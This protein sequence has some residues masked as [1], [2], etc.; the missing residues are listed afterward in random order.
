M[1]VKQLLITLFLLCFLAI[2]VGIGILIFQFRPIDSASTVTAQFVVTKGDTVS[3]VA[4]KLQSQQFIRSTLLFKVMTKIVAQDVVVQPGTYSLSKSMNPAQ[5]LA[6]LQTQTQ[7]VWVTLIEGWRNEEMAQELASK[8][9]STF[10]QQEFITLAKQKEGMLFP[11][12]YHIAK[13]AT[14]ENII[15]MLSATFT[16]RYA[17]AVAAVGPSAMTQDEVIT[18]A[19]LVQREAKDPDDMKIVAGIL[20]NRLQKNMPLQLDASLQYVKG[21]DAAQQTW[22]PVVK[23][24]DKDIDSLWNT[25]MHTGL[26]AGPICNPGLDAIQAAIHPDTTNYYYYI[27]DRQG[28]LHYAVT[29]EEHKK[30]IQQYLVN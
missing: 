12:T 14:A 26:P 25:Y 2:S 11:D 27:S 23:S 3:K 10:N 13:E 19:S 9:P 29:F 22:W 15:D 21:Y 28:V 7:D 18:L 8:L 16:K 20:E 6:I 30:N 4:S 24:E 5:I 1:H 17:T